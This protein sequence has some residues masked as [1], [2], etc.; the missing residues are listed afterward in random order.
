VGHDVHYFEMAGEATHNILSKK[1]SFSSYYNFLQTIDLR[2]A[3]FV[4]V[5]IRLGL[6]I[7]GEWQDKNF[8]LKFTDIDYH[9]FSDAARHVLDGKSPFLRPTYR[10]SP[11]LAFLLVPNHQAFFSFGKVLF[12]M[13]DL[14]V[15]VIIYLILTARGV[16]KTKINFSVSLWLLNPL[17]ATVSSRGNAES[18][19]ALLVLLTLYFIV[20]RHI[21]A[22]GI[23]FGLAIHFKV[24]PIVYSLPLY[25]FINEDYCMESDENLGT[26]RP[27]HFSFFQVIYNPLKLK[28]ALISVTTV[29]ALTGYFY[30][31]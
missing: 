20:S 18:I 4:A 17:T 23:C 3:G 28:F 24:F 6:L 15:G 27:K 10:Y 5:L 2:V 16:Q 1:S 22:A 12:V 30:I 7:Y 19:L 21:F 25:L 9:V 31:L 11:L 26:S 13:C 14:L 29:S 8:A